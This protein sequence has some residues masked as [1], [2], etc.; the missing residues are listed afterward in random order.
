VI[1]RALLAAEDLGYRATLAMLMPV[2]H[3]L[4][5]LLARR[6]R[7]GSVL[8]VSAMVHVP[9]Y[10]SRILREHGVDADYL[11]VGDSPWW[12][13]ADYQF[14]ATRWPIASVVNEMWWVWRVVSRYEIVHSHF[15]VTVSR[16]A[17]EWRLLTEMG[18]KLVVHYRGCEIRDRELNQRLHPAVNI[19]QDCDYDPPPCVSCANVRRRP[20]ARQYGSAFLVTTP[21]MKDFV[22]EATHIPFF[23]TRADAPPASSASHRAHPRSSPFK[24]VHVTVHPGI[25]GSRHIRRAVGALQARG[26]SIDFVEL[27]GVPH[28]KVLDELRDAD[29]SI[30]KMKMGYYAN[31]QIESLAAGVPAVTYVRPELRT[32]A[33][34]ASGLIFAEL[35]TLESVLEYYL[36][37][38]E[39]LAAKRACARAS[40]LTL[41]DN[42][43]IA[44]EYAALYSR[45]R[46]RAV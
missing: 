34:D 22:P 30:G 41:H 6:V 25:E 36:S 9:Y 5:R 21:D 17:W 8:H 40:I 15:M 24:V 32:P 28:E 2:N 3:L 16:A 13:K 1:K 18:R 19:C 38:P 43:V 31:F 35:D 44:R 11:A 12:N 33:L 46:A 14:R 23:V 27:H 20:L 45:L 7:P 4:A 29:L 10:M 26:W 37:H 39:A 42:A